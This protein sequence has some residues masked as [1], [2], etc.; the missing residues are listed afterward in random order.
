MDGRLIN[1]NQLISCLNELQSAD[2]RSMD[3]CSKILCLVYITAFPLILR[4]IL[5]NYSKCKL[6]QIV[7][8]TSTISFERF[9]FNLI[10]FLWVLFQYSFL[11]IYLP[12]WKFYTTNYHKFCFL[13]CTNLKKFSIYLRLW[14]LC[15]SFLK[16]KFSY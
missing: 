5:K 8:V 3:R 16:P 6:S 11:H 7:R 12:L 2:V 4:E 1:C 13:I 15:I 14:Y 10:L 9:N